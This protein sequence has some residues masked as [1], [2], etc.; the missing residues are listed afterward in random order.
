M[1]LA[2]KHIK[3]INELLNSERVAC[4]AFERTH[5]SDAYGMR[6]WTTMGWEATQALYNEYGIVPSA[7][8]LRFWNDM[9]ARFAPHPQMT[10]EVSPTYYGA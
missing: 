2:K 7:G 6:L 9:K 4:D 5:A 8:S 1:K 10:N 3:R